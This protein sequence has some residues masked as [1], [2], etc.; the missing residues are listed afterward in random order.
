MKK[1]LLKTDLLLAI[2]LS[3]LVFL[4]PL[5]GNAQACAGQTTVA[6]GGIYGFSDMADPANTQALRSSCRVR[7][8][9]HRWI[10]ARTSVGEK[11]AILS[12]FRY[13]GR[14]IVELDM[15]PDAVDYF[16]N[17]YNKTFL[18]SG[19]N[20]S[21]AHVNGFAN[22]DTLAHWKQFVDQG[23]RVGLSTMAVVYSPNSGQF[24]NG[25]F[26]SP[27]WNA[28]RAAALYSGGLTIDA[29]SDFFFLKGPDYQQFIFDEIHW[30][31]HKHILTTF[32]ISPGHS[33][34]NFAA[35]TRR[36]VGILMQEHTVPDEFI[37]ENYDAYPSQPYP[38]RVGNEHDPET[39][40]GVALWILN[41]TR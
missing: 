4:Y 20:S 19:V 5:S 29:P 15:K 12:N 32:I 31:K 24:Q 37:V 1:F 8:Y 39:E 38:N 30:A 28:V 10:W 17:F 35:L 11:R 40:A 14:P 21:E 2:I 41:H 27:I 6:I 26:G 7:L 33:K 3:L 34:S 36:L 25:P 22:T 23:R 9:L 13:N 18:Q 16:Q